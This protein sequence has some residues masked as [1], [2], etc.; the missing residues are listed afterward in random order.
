[1]IHIIVRTRVT[2]FDKKSNQKKFKKMLSHFPVV[3]YTTA[4]TIPRKL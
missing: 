2:F 4:V 1:M 3:M